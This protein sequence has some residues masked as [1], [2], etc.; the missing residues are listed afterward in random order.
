ML[1]SKP[2]DEPM[3]TLSALRVRRNAVLMCAL[4]A[5]AIATAQSIKPYKIFAMGTAVNA[6]A[7]D[8]IFVGKHSVWVSYTNGAD[9]TGKFGSSTV[10]Q[11]D[12]KGNVEH[13]YS[14]AGYVDGLKQDPKTGLVWAM[15]NQDGNSTLTL[16]D[17]EDGITKDSPLH[18]A[19][20]SPSRGYDDVVF[21]G[22]EIYLSYT[23]PTGPSDATI[24]RLENRTSPLK[25]SPV[26]TMGA[27]G[28]D[29]ATGKHNQP[30]TQNDPDSL[31]LT[32]SGALMLTS[33]DDGQLIFV[34]HPGE[35]QSVSFLTLLDPSSGKAVSGLDD[36][37]FVTAEKGTFY[38]T[39]TNANQ[40]LTIEAEDLPIG[41]LYA[42]VGSLNEF[43]WVDL[44]TGLVH[45]LVNNL[46]APHGLAFVPHHKQND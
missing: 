13:Q 46:N 10:V 21:L 9:S 6:T 40:V 12:L 2:E 15:Q 37:V 27:T 11:Y 19:V 5:T 36:A 3:I 43:A 28:T 29:L 16:I 20:S 30:T 22:D 14:I 32:P 24:Q 18:Y 1:V 38:L 35:D 17:P 31:K 25:V 8:S 7:P 39:N 26:L 33:G 4:A 34:G 44:K 41:S 42:N 45:A 23:N